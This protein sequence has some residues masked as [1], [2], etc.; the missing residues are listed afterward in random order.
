VNGSGAPPDG[1]RPDF[2]PALGYRALTPL[3]DAAIAAL[4]REHVW[5]ARMVAALDLRAGERVLDV[6]CGT[7]SL[8]LALSAAA[9]ATFLMGVDP[10]GDVLKRARAKAASADIAFAHGFF[11]ESFI[12]REGR[13]DAVVSSLVLHQTPI[14]TKRSLLAGMRRALKGGGRLCLADYG[15]QTGLM[16]L[17]FRASVQALDGVEDTQPNADGVLSE[18]LREAGFK[19]IVEVEQIRTATG[20]ICIWIARP[21]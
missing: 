2:T 8:L 3:Y 21:S 7:G 4:T 9:P 10:D 12:A 16:R 20:S 15:R 5:R 11:D 19:T 13:F 1:T 18:L 17:L 14:E 6:G